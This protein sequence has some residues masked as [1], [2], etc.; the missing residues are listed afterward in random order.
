MIR[1]LL[2]LAL[3]VCLLVTFQSSMAMARDITIGYQEVYDPW[4][5]S[6]ETRQFEKATGK[7][8][9]WRKFD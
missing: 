3:G 7:K 8:I 9:D 4:L 5:W 1:R 2:N 6:I